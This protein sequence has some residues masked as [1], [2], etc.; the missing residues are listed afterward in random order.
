MELSKRLTGVASMVSL[1]AKVADI[2]CDHGFV[3]I[4][5]IENRIADKV[6]AMDVNEGPLKRAGEH[7]KEA[8]LDAYIET[9]LSDGGAALEAGEADTAIIAGMGGRLMVRIL[10]EAAERSLHFRELVLQPQSEI[11]KVREYLW[12]SGYEIIAEDMVFE[13]G[14]YYQIMKAVVGK[15]NMEAKIHDFAKLTGFAKEIVREAFLCY[16]PLLLKE[17]H[18]VCLDYLQYEKENAGRISQH[19]MEQK[20]TP[21][22]VRRLRELQHKLNV[23]QCA[24]KVGKTVW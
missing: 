22:T 8:G 21:E 19:I 16:G 10:S 5:L 12:S 23:L 13:D 2:G 18:P 14:K 1:H 24:V 4:Y 9:R 11:F 20:E 17:S 7:I 3:S 15:S 6:I